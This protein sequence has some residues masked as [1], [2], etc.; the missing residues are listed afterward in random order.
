MHC[1]ITPCH[2]TIPRWQPR[3]CCTILSKDCPMLSRYRIIKMAT[4][5]GR[6]VA[7]T[8]NV[9]AQYP[10]RMGNF[11]IIAPLWRDSGCI[12]GLVI[13]EGHQW[14]KSLSQCLLI[15]PFV[16]VKFRDYHVLW[17]TCSIPHSSTYHLQTWH[18][19]VVAPSFEDL[20]CLFVYL[21]VKFIYVFNRR[22]LRKGVGLLLPHHDC[23]VPPQ[24]AY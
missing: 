4:C 5:I 15:L 13:I 17:M 12:Q 18:V 1:T 6:I 14:S 22:R 2:C 23:T 21:F 9:I 20:N 10:K 19:I 24:Q 11:K 8:C 7:P 3:R 16:Q